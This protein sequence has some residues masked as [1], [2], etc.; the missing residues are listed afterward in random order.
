M[1]NLL[2]KQINY[3][4]DEKGSWVEQQVYEATILGELQLTDLITREI[5]YY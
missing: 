5:E 3:R 1:N 2:Q 4:L